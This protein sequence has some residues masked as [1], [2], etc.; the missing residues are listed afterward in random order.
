MKSWSGY[1]TNRAKHYKERKHSDI[2]AEIGKSPKAVSQW[3]R[4]HGFQKCPNYTEMETY[5][6]A[7]FTASHCLA[8]I[9]HKSINALKIKQ[10]RMRQLTRASVSMR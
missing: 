9:P 2:A 4:I 6:L 10:C 1:C 7:N 8:F 3:L 5:L